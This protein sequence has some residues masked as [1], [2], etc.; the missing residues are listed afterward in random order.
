VHHRECCCRGCSWCCDRTCCWR[1]K[2]LLAA[3]EA[4]QVVRKHTAWCVCVCVLGVAS[5]AAAGVI[6]LDTLAGPVAANS[7]PCATLQL[8]SAAA[9]HTP[10]RQDMLSAS[11]CCS[12]M[13][14]SGDGGAPAMARGAAAAAAAGGARPAC[15]W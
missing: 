13:G 2:Q 7:T 15:W 9:A 6:G 14:W 3:V 10:G 8:A 4:R 11:G 12:C 5:A 1:H